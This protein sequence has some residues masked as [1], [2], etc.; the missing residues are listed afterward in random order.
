MAFKNVHL[1]SL[2][3]SMKL[4]TYFPIPRHQQPIDYDSSVLLMGSCFS[5]NIGDRFLYHGF[6]A[7]IN[8]F[9]VIFNPYSLSLLIDKSLNDNFTEADVQ[10]SFSYLA[11]SDLD[12]KNA[13]ETLVNIKNAG[14]HLK[15]CIH[16]AT[17]IILTLGTAWVYQLKETGAIVANC[18]QQPQSIFDKKLLSIDQITRSLEK[19]EEQIHKANPTARI[20]YTLSPV[21]HTK[22]G[23]VQNT[24]S[25]ARLHDAIQQACEKSENYYFPAYEILVDELRDYRFYAADMIH[26]NETAIDVVWLRFRESVL[27]SNTLQTMK[28]VEKYRNL[29]A[30]RPKNLAAHEEQ[31]EKS[32]KLLQ[33]KYPYLNLL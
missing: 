1:Q 14:N 7:V 6:D 18:H 10:D 29:Q 25:K 8:P 26:P 15:T 22:D 31:L 3:A 28:A 12:G 32:L 27:H 21:R 9:G 24:R 4:T 33:E 16:S 5:Q 19:I 11:H 23:M 20:I 17:H 2:L 30:H 13:E